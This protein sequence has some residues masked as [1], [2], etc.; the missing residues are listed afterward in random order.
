MDKTQ[1]GS[2]S[3]RTWLITGAS[4]GIGLAVAGRVGDQGDNVVAIGRTL[5]GLTPL[6]ERFGERVLMRGIDIADAAAVEQVVHEGLDAYGRIDVAHNSAGF[7]VFGA[8]EEAGADS[9][10]RIFET[11]VFGAANVIRSVLPAMRT[12][13][14]GHILN[15]SSYFGQVSE[16]GV[17]MLSATKFALEAISEA[18]AQE[19]SPLGI[20][21]TIVEPSLTATPFLASMDMAETIDAYDPTVRAT[22]KAVGAIDPST[23]ND[24]ERVAELIVKVT[25]EESPPLRLPTGGQSVEAMRAAIEARLE[26]LNG[27]EGLSRT[28]DGDGAVG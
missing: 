8:I 6:K 12:Q 26:Q 16:A 27:V 2:Q 19:V 25:E 17:G 11:N 14:S 5:D 28:V 9:V 3:P 13:G 24:P 7:G 1:T 4:S 21:V 15:G 22:L 18:L 10:R 23:M 20:K